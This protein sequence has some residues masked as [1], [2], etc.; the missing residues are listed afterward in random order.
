MDGGSG[1][2]ASEAEED[3]PDERRVQDRI[4]HVE[5]AAHPRRQERRRILHAAG[6]LDIQTSL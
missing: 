1:P 6:A 5:E 4:E 2:A 3:E